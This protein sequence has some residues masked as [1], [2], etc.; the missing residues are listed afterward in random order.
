[1]KQSFRRNIDIQVEL[2][3]STLRSVSRM[4]DEYHDMELH[5]TIDLQTKAITEC[6]PAMHKHP[7]PACPG[8]LQAL[9]GVVGLTIDL[10][11]KRA[12]R[13]AVPKAAGCTHFT[14]TF[15]NTFDYL[16]QKLYWDGLG[17]DIT[18]R[19][20]HEQLILAFLREQNTCAAFNRESTQTQT[21]GHARPT[22]GRG[23]L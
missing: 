14:E 16:L 8:A 10:R 22:R 6:R 2:E 23:G 15:D 13:N 18:D 19:D 3:G 12:F 20:A 1:M 9:Q 11:I 4:V 17:A 7:T 21:Y 5:L